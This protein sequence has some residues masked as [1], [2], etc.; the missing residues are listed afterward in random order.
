[1]QDDLTKLFRKKYN[2]SI[3]HLERDQALSATVLRK[4]M[5][6]DAFAIRRL[7]ESRDIYR[8][9]IGL[10]LQRLMRYFLKSHAHYIR[11]RAREKKR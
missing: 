3:F 4:M 10:K 2:R 7:L 9:T 8:G 11:V 6:E 5:E 1:M